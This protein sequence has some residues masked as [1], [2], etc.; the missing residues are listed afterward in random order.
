L[1]LPGTY[2]RV[3]GQLKQKNSLNIIHLKE[4]QPPYPLLEIPFQMAEKFEAQE[5][6][7]SYS[8]LLHN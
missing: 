2:F 8:M 3:A 5:Q 7:E 4:Q 1:L 6:S